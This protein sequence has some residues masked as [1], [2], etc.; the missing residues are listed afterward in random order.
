MVPDHTLSRGGPPPWRRPAVRADGL[1]ILKAVVAAVCAWL[2]VTRVLDS[3]LPFLAP[4]SALLTVRGSV[5]RSLRHGAE[6]L[7]ATVTGVLVSFAAATWLGFGVVGLTVALL[8]G[9]LASRLRPLRNE[10][11]AVATTA[12]FVLTTGAT[13]GRIALADRVVDVALGV[14]VGVVVNVAV[15]APLDVR[16][17][18]ERAVEVRRAIGRLVDEMVDQLGDDGSPERAGEWISYTR[19]MDDDLAETW[20][21]VRHAQESSWWNPRPSSRDGRRE[22]DDLAKVLRLLEDAVAQLR[23]L[24]RTVDASTASAEEWPPEFRRE[25]LLALRECGHRLGPSSEAPAPE[26]DPGAR[27]DEMVVSLSIDDLPRLLW[28]T[29]GALISGLRNLVAIA[30]ELRTGWSSGSSHR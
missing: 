5:Y 28:P 24:A 27:V 26:P 25:W 21:V 12:L 18:R 22:A 13:G 10:G 2:V 29:Y 7:A 15:V 3:D 19:R 8:V 6:S 23:S 1:L 11:V 20:P 16:A 9:M 17:A 14:A 4:W 30:D